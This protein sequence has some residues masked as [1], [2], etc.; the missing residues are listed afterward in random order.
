M[1][2]KLG[3]S[4]PEKAF[5]VSDDV[6]DPDPKVLQHCWEKVVMLCNPRLKDETKVTPRLLEE[7]KDLLELRRIGWKVEACEKILEE[8]KL[9]AENFEAIR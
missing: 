5:G 2:Y 1:G 9:N 7:L 4:F 3:G 8:K 6:S